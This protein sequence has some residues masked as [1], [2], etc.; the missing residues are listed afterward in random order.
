MHYG[1]TLFS[2]VTLLAFFVNI[3]YGYSLTARNS[4]AVNGSQESKLKPFDD[5][6]SWLI[7]LHF[8]I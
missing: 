7:L 6:K 2:A 1:T 3:T 8:Y 4:L 5:P